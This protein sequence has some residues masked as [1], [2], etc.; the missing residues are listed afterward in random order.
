LKQRAPGVWEPLA[1]GTEEDLHAVWS[2]GSEVWAAGDDG[3]VLASHD[4]GS[5][6]RRI[7]SGTEEDLRAIAGAPGGVYVSGE[8]GVLKKISNTQAVSTNGGVPAPQG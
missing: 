3:V 6:W 1:S 8:N 2:S 4:G 7:D 5:S